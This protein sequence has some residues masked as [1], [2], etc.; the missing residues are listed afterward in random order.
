MRSIAQLHYS[1]MKNCG[2]RIDTDVARW[3]KTLIWKWKVLIKLIILWSTENHFVVC[4]TVVFLIIAPCIVLFPVCF[5]KTRRCIPRGCVN[6]ISDIYQMIRNVWIYR[7]ATAT[8]SVDS[9]YS[10]PSCFDALTSVSANAF[11]RWTVTSL[12]C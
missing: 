12:Q 8:T 9:L 4:V 7:N 5:G 3:V 2:R 10:S 6:N 1:S 11:I